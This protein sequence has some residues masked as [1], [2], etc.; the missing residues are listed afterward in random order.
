VGEIQQLGRGSDLAFLTA[1]PRLLLAAALV[2]LVGLLVGLLLAA[3]LL[4]VGLLAAALLLLARTGI[5]RLLI[6]ILILVGI[7]RI[8]HSHLLEGSGKPP[9]REV[10]ARK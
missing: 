9:A 1:L 4:L 10:N 5:V 7:A 2:L 3:L 8:A 6:R